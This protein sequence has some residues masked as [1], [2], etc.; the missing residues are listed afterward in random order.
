MINRHNRGH[1]VTPVF[2][3]GSAPAIF[4]QGQ[5]LIVEVYDTDAPFVNWN[6]R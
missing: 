5:I 4:G 6:V 1:R 2:R 3:S